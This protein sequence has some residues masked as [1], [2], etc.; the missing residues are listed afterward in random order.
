MTIYQILEKYKGKRKDF[1]GNSEFE[2]FIKNRDLLIKLPRFEFLYNHEKEEFDV[3]RS[4]IIIRSYLNKQIIEKEVSSIVEQLGKEKIDVRQLHAI[5]KE[6]IVDLPYLVK[7]KLKVYIPIF[8]IP[9]NMIYS[10]HPEKLLT[11]PYNLLENDF[12]ESVIDLFDIYGVDLYDSY[13]TSL[14]KVS[15]NGKEVAFFNYDTNTIF[16][17][18]NQGRL[19]NKIVLF[20][21]YIKRPI[22]NHMLERLRPV[23]DA[24]F[25]NDRKGF[26]SALYQN[27]F[28][29]ERLKTIIEKEN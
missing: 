12:G 17:V 20:D 19:D 22:D 16:I 5:L 26:I 11:Y 6:R 7:D 29:S 25:K 10:K 2:F 9:M 13:F 23:V 18:N 3:I 8:S 28:I 24:Y 21:K 15:T 14:I 27:D 1:E 4:N